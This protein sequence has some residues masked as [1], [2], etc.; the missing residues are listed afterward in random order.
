M[1]ID[2]I[3]ITK[4]VLRIFGRV[5]APRAPLSPPYACYAIHYGSL[6]LRYLETFSL[7]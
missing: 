4:N 3:V 2:I 6:V 7:S 5:K 1:S